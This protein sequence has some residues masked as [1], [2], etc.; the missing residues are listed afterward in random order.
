[1][2]EQVTIRVALKEGTPIAAILTLK[3]KDVLVYKYGC[4]DSRFHAFG[5]IPSLIWGAIQDA[6]AKGVRSLDLGRT[7]KDNE[8]LVNFKDRLGATRSEIAYFRLE[9]RS[10]HVPGLRW[11]TRTAKRIFAH[12]PHGVRSTAGSLLYKHVG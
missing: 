7:D 3:F 2:G 5:G 6:K 10:S 8:G 4:S 11:S 9:K 12:L 1:L